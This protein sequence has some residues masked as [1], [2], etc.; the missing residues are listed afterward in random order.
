MAK[1]KM[2]LL[3]RVLNFRVEVIKF[4]RDY[5]PVLMTHI[6]FS[7]SLVLLDCLVFGLVACFVAQTC[8]E[9]IGTVSSCNHM[10]YSIVAIITQLFTVATHVI[11]KS[12]PIIS[13]QVCTSIEQT[14]INQYHNIFVGH[15]LGYL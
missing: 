13:G 10:D 6:S 15:H 9:L 1:D 5:H 11:Q 8:V 12:L 14:S 3:L 2:N 4:V 7:Q